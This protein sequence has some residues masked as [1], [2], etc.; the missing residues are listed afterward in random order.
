MRW[1][2]LRVS[3]SNQDQ[4]LK[5]VRVNVRTNTKPPKYLRR[6]QKLVRTTKASRG[7]TLKAPVSRR[8]FSP[9]AW[10]NDRPPGSMAP[11][12]TTQ[13]LMSKVYEDA[14]RNYSQS[15]RETY[16]RDEN[17]Y[18]DCLSPMSVYA[19]LDSRYESSID[20]QMQDF[21]EV[22]DQNW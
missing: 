10:I 20:F 9:A 13:Y 3:A 6:E 5:F 16:V 8:R 1:K 12:N 7:K 14:T 22:F 4:A 11:G 17:L 19:E 15:V 2:V 21:E 18:R